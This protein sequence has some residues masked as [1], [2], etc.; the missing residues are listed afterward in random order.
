MVLNRPLA[1][2]S[3][4]DNFFYARGGRFL[5]QKLNR[6]LI[7]D[8]EHLL[9]LCLGRRQKASAEPRDRNNSFCD[10]GNHVIDFVNESASFS[11]SSSRTNFIE[12]SLV[13]MGYI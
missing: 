8:C 12:L 9:R 11:K 13:T 1:L 10:F 3:Y 4:E 5:N 7:H 6:G 2:A